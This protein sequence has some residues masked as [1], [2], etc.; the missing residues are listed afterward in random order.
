MRAAADNRGEH[1]A[2]LKASKRRRQ[3]CHMGVDSLQKRRRRVEGKA[4]DEQSCRQS[5]GRGQNEGYS[6]SPAGGSR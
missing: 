3:A 6:T 1:K 2:R 4:L 5:H